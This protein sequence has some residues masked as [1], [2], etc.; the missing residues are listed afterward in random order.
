MTMVIDK[1]LLEWLENNDDAPIEEQGRRLKDNAPEEI[2]IK[3]N[4]WLKLIEKHGFR[5]NR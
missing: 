5:I 2:K 1:E 4:E 3:Y